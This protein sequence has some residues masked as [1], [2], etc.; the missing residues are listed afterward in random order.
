VQ[1]T[2]Q[3]ISVACLLDPFSPHEVSD[4][5]ESFF[6]VLMYRVVCYRSCTKEEAMQ[7]VFDAH[8]EPDAQGLI[9]GG[10]GKLTSLDGCTFPCNVIEA[11]VA[12]PCA[13]IIKEMWEIFKNLYYL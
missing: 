12:A 5:L 10:K 11:A 3:F 8:F 1:G 7:D 13:K 9:T 4:D 2:W 6:W